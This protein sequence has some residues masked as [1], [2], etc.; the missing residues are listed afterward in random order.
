MKSFLENGN[1]HVNGNGDPDLRLDGVLGRAVEGLD[2]QVLL[3]PFEEEFDL[4]TALVDLRDRK[5]RQRK[6]VGDENETLGCLGVDETNAAQF[7]GIGLER[8]EAHELDGL[9]AAQAG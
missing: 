1:Q 8:I 4:P 9:V 3:D 5:W 6:A 2:P 7:F